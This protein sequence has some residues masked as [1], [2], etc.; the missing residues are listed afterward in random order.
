MG[1]VK[2][3]KS[4]QIK[5]KNRC[6]Y[7]TRESLATNKLPSDVIQAMRILTAAPIPSSYTTA[8]LTEM[9]RRNAVKIGQNN[10]TV[11]SVICAHNVIDCTNTRLISDCS[12]LELKNVDASIQDLFKI[13]LKTCG[14]SKVVIFSKPHYPILVVDVFVDLVFRCDK[15]AEHIAKI[16]S[17]LISYDETEDT[18]FAIYAKK[19]CTGCNECHGLFDL[20]VYDFTL[21]NNKRTMLDISCKSICEKVIARWAPVSNMI[22]YKDDERDARIKRLKEEKAAR[23][24]D[25]D[26][27]FDDDEF[28]DDE[29]N[30]DDEYDEEIDTA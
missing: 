6:M 14:S 8:G 5:E 3:S 26:D 25:E 17:H 30:E 9:M 15:R 13:L 12:E 29:Y 4:P 23:E 27:E 16:R 21:V 20:T 7:V 24:E 2:K 10:L 28:D 19:R 1:R 18:M 22:W 11:S